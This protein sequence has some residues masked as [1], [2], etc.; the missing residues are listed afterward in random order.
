LFQKVNQKQSENAKK[1][2][3]EFISNVLQ[4]EESLEEFDQDARD[5]DFDK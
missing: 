2:L 3:R 5:I 1:R 4:E